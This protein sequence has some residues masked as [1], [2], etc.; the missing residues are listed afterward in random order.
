[1]T[2]EQQV[3]Q[4]IDVIAVLSE[5]VADNNV[6]KNVRLAMNDLV[7]VLNSGDEQSIKVHEALNI[8]DTISNDINLDSYS[9]TQMFSII[10]ILENMK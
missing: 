5:M 6:P 10:S 7:S 8:L 9:R 3:E 2:M 4:F 1:M